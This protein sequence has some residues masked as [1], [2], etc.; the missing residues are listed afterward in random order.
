MFMT[1]EL[2]ILVLALC[3][4]SLF[5]QMIFGEYECRIT[6]TRRQPLITLS[7]YLSEYIVQTENVHESGQLN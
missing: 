4:L 5:K 7:V 3:I 6:T 2:Q 1:A